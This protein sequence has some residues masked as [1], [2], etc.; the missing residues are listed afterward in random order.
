MRFAAAAISA[1]LL[2]A[3]SPSFAQVPPAAIE[4]AVGAQREAQ[5]VRVDGRHDFHIKP[6]RISYRDEGG[7]RVTVVEGQLSHTLR[8]RP[9]DQYFYSFTLTPDG[10]VSFSEQINRGGFRSLLSRVPGSATA[11]RALRVLGV[12]PPA[13]FS[14]LAR[15]IGQGFASG[16]GWEVSARRIVTSIAIRVANGRR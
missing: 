12:S 8:Y 13:L 14:D 9:D 15:L 7:Q 10:M 3:A 2:A 5:N 1:A 16:T 6:V 11:R 4:R